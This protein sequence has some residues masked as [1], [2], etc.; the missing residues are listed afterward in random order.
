MSKEM[1]ERD[2]NLLTVMKV[3]NMVAYFL[4]PA[5]VKTYVSALLCTDFEDGDGTI[6]SYMSVD[7]SVRW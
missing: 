2:A 4:L 1:R 5:T 3:C 6:E 7:M